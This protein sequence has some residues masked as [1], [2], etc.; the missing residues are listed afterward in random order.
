[1]EAP[2]ALRDQDVAAYVAALGLPGIVDLHV[3]FMPERVQ[4]KVWAHFDRLDP[5]WPIV[6]RAGE[7]ERLATLAALGVHHHTALAYAHRPGMAA[8]L[9]RHTLALA[10]AHPAVVGSFTF[11]PEPGVEAEV[12]RSLAAGGTVAKVHLQVGKF[13]PLDPLLDLVW[14]ELARRRVPVVLHAGAVPDGSGGEEFC[15]AGKVAGLLDRFPDLVLVVAH[16]GAPDFGDFL[17]LA[18]A[19]PTLRLDTAM[20]FGGP[21]A[22]GAFPAELVE[23]LGGLGERVLF[24]SDFPSVAWPFAGQVGGLAGLGLGEEWLRGVLWRNGAR[25]LN[26]D[27][28]KEG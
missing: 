8:W 27:A 4:A 28:G 22:I 20:V 18:E 2:P 11:Y 26:L 24:G 14:A 19:A 21:Q 6:Y 16:L 15:G 9:N 10:A 17:G 12:E 25:L 13:H 23:R 5:P 7:A 3:H 1:M